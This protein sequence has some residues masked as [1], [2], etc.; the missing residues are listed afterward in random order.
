MTKKMTKWSVNE[1]STLLTLVAEHGASEG[2][3][4]AAKQLK[5]TENACS[6]Q[7][8]AANKTKSK[9][10]ASNRNV[11][12][13]DEVATLRTSI[14]SHGVMA[15]CFE[16]SKILSRTA[17]A[18]QAK[19]KQLCLKKAHEPIEN[20]RPIGSPSVKYHNGTTVEAEII[21]QTNDLIV[22]KHGDMVV[23][24]HL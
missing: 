12:S 7:Y 3:R 15:G 21:A 4:R 6:W 18:C 17:T 8:Y 9:G 16:T 19:W 22:A 20:A 2:C 1:K 24:S 10:S 23:T 5:R 13:A 11:W 14:V